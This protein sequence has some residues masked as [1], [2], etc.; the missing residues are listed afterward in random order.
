MSFK[1]K[2]GQRFRVIVS[3]ACFYATAKQIRDGVGDFVQCNQAVREALRSLQDTRSGSG[4][5]DQ[6]AV[7]LAGTW[8]GLQ[9]QL[10]MA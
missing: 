10:N 1:F 4:I 8:E 3:N 7:G 6:C 2:Q 9:V 5:A